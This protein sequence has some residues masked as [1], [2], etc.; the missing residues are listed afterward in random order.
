MDDDVVDGVE[1]AAVEVI[2]EDGCLVWCTGLH[3]Y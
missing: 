2:E 3:V 1:S